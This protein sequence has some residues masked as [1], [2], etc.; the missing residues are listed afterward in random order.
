MKYGLL[1]LMN[2]KTNQFTIA[3]FADNFVCVCE[4]WYVI[5][6]KQHRLREI[7]NRLLR[8]YLEQRRK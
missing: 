5:L 8:K 2:L 6:R 4:T 1:V 3:N 7:E